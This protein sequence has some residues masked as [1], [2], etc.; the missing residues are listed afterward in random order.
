VEA[1]RAQ[2]LALAQAGDLRP[3]GVMGTR[4]QVLHDLVR[5]HS[6]RLVDDRPLAD[7]IDALMRRMRSNEVPTELLPER[8]R[9]PLHEP[10]GVVGFQGYTGKGFLI[11]I[12]ILI[13]G[14]WPH[15]AP[16]R[17]ASKLPMSRIEHRT[18]NTRHR[19][20]GAVGPSA[21][22]MDVGCSAFA[23]RVPRQRQSRKEA[24]GE[25]VT[26]G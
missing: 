8:P 26:V 15:G 2:A 21:L 5:Q 10:A 16:I 24:L 23:S 14:S 18:S 17:L 7:D 12:L 25:R 22:R 1:A 3:D 20:S 9:C 19:T 13:S 4:F 11:L 6:A